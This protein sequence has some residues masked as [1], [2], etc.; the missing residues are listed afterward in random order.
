MLG[1]LVIQLCFPLLK[2]IDSLTLPELNMLNWFSSPKALLCTLDCKPVLYCSRRK[3]TSCNVLC[4]MTK[5]VQL[6]KIL[7]HEIDMMKTLLIFSVTSDPQVLQWRTFRL[8]CSCRPPCWGPRIR[9]CAARSCGRWGGSGSGAR[10]T[11]SSWSGPSSLWPSLPPVCGES[12]PL[13]IH[14]SF[15]CWRW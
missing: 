8:S 5:W 9:F 7:W 4:R 10:S 2:E 6:S 1:L 12:L 15:H 14:S 13:S 11:S 3:L